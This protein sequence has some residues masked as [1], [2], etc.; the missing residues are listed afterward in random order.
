MKDDPATKN[1]WNTV[2][3]KEFDNMAQGDKKIGT[4]GTNSIFVLSHDKICEIP[5]DQA[6][7]YTRIAVDYRPQKADPN[8]IRITVGEN[9]I[10]Y[11]GKLTTRTADLTT[12]KLLWNSVISTKDARFM[13][14][15][16]RNFHLGTA[17]ERYEYMKILL[18]LFPPHIIK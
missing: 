8:R 1:V 3:G 18:K 11:P 10:D 16:I 2:F 17:M 5:A 12:S 6:V 7:T 4:K 14:I 13:G 9:L 15:D